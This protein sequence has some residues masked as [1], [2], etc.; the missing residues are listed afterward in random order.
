MKAALSLPPFGQLAD[1]GL[2]VEIALAAEEA[3][4]D[5]CFLWDHVYR[6]ET[7][8]REILDP[9]VILGAQA[10]ATDRIRLGSVA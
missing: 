9:W 8:P 5:G 10:L 4:I 6:P 2:L 1:P 7:D 3:D